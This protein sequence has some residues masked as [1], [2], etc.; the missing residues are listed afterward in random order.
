[1]L[2]PGY[3]C[4]T[5]FG[6]DGEFPASITEQDGWLVSGS[7]SGAYEDHPWIEP[8]ED[9]LRSAYAASVPV[10]GICFGHQ[11]LAQALGDQTHRPQVNQHSRGTGGYRQ[12][13]GSKHRSMSLAQ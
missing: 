10:V 1:M 7:R 13:A 9:F 2:A 4:R 12:H 11:I 8:L 5:D 3:A 6:V